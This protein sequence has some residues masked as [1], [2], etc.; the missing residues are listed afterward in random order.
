MQ[1]VIKVEFVMQLIVKVGFSL[2]INLRFV[3]FGY[4]KLGLSSFFI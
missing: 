2:A 1:F 4:I 3:F